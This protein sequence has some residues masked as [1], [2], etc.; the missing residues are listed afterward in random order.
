MMVCISFLI[1]Q[2]KVDDNMT[3]KEVKKYIGKN[4]ILT[5]VDGQK[6]RGVII[7]TEAGFDTESGKEEIELYTGKIYIGIPLDEIESIMKSL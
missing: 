2:E 3:Y 6:F 7:N 1:I 4:V 5:D